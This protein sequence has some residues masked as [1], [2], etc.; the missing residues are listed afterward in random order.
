MSEDQNIRFLIRFKWDT[1]ISYLVV[2]LYII[3][4]RL[5]VHSEEY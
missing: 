4:T 2:D 1:E 3:V 5:L